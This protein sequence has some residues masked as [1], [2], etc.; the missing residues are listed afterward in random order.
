MR[1]SLT[2]FILKYL[3]AYHCSAELNN[4][5]EISQMLDIRTHQ[6]NSREVFSW[7]PRT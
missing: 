2:E 5:T 1:V 6:Q 4:R 3:P 7:R